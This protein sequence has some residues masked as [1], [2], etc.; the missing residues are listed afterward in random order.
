MRYSLVG[1]A[2]APTLAF[3]LHDFVFQL[4]DNQHEASAGFVLTVMGLL[5]VWIATGYLAA[6]GASQRAALGAA[7]GVSS[8]L[9]LWATFI[10]LNWFFTERMS[11]E[12]DRLRAFHASGAATLREFLFRRFTPG[13]FPLLAGVAAVAGAAGSL[14]RRATPPLRGR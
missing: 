12:T 11:Y 3:V 14:L 4:P 6:R 9:V 7:A 1:V 13:P 5:V 8:V 10:A 2:L